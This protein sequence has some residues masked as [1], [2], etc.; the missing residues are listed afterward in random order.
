MNQKK[1]LIFSLLILLAGAVLT[2]LIFNTEPTASQTGASVE[3]AILVDLVEADRGT[4]TPIIRA[5]GTVEPSQDI[6]L[7]PRVEGE[8]VELSQNFTPGGYVE[9]G[10][11][12]LQIDPSDYRNALKQRQSE[13]RSAEANLMIEMGQQNVAEQDY[14]LLDDSLS[15][16]SKALVLREPQL[17]TARAMVESAEAAVQQAELNLERTTIRAPFDAYILSRTANV[18]SQVSPGDQ[19][20]RLVGRDTYWVSAMIPLAS[21]RWISVPDN[22]GGG[23][24][25]RIRNRTSWNEDEYRTGEI[26]RLVGAL[27]DQTRMASLLISVDD[28]LSYRSEN[29]ENPKLMIGSFVEANIRAAQL[30]NVIRLNRDYVRQNDTVWVMEESR[31]QIQDLE[32]LFRDADYAYITS[33]LEDGDK[34]VTTTL[35]TVVE[36]TRLR[37]EN[38]SSAPSDSTQASS[39][40][41]AE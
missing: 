32:I 24:E 34:I 6:M 22:G 35:S 13:L 11:L 31:L 16:E 26:F 30:E 12:L 1:T 20:G 15:S 8:I 38:G 29:S 25:V 7:S 2:I 14:A 40:S 33:G 5:T 10:D 23:S 18:G 41:N 17:N 27:E 37:T 36:G 3:T 21:L 39:E 19:L 28:P 9:E 4:Y